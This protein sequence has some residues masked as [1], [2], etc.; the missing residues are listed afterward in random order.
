MLNYIW[1]GLMAIAL[2]VA[3]ING[4]ADAVTKAAVDSATSAVQRLM[5]EAWEKRLIPKQVTV[6][7]SA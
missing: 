7:F 1:F 5:D 3:A 6:E 2:I 4:T